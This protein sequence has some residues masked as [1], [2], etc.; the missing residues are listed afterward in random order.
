MIDLITSLETMRTFALK[1][2]G[3]IQ[4]CYHYLGVLTFELDNILKFWNERR[5]FLK[6][7]FNIE[8]N[9]HALER[10]LDELESYV[11][12]EMAAI[13]QNRS[14]FNAAPDAVAEQRE[15]L[16]YELLSLLNESIEKK[17][18]EITA[19][20]EAMGPRGSGHVLQD[21]QHAT[22]FIEEFNRMVETLEVGNL[23]GWINYR[24]FADRGMRPT[25]NI[26]KNAG[27]RLKGAQERIKALTDVI[28]VSGLIVQSDATRRNT[29]VLRSI[30]SEFRRAN[31]LLF[32]RY[33][34]F[35]VI[36]GLFLYV[37]TKW[38][39]L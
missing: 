21:I 32:T 4:N 12:R 11:S 39:L 18:I 26:I 20:M 34:L 13:S 10:D 19:D 30:A 31:S 5:Q 25:F 7:K 6:D 8:R 16:Y 38:K 29:A 23:H 33:G 27:E 1:N 9:A 2:F 37:A 14:R 35:I 3:L 28:Q 22:Y 36:V 15:R 17:L 24:Q